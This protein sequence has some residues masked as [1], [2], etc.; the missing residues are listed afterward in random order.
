MA[1]V[2]LL[3]ANRRWEDLTNCLGLKNVGKSLKG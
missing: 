2:G 3:L 1:V